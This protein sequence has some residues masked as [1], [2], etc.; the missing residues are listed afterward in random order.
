[1]VRCQEDAALVSA[2]AGDAAAGAAEWTCGVRVEGV[3]SARAVKTA[4]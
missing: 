3:S 4:L 1:M 2:L